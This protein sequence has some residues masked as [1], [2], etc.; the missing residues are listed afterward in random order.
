MQ[1]KILK[2]LKKIFDKYCDEKY[3]LSY[4]KLIFITKLLLDKV[5]L[6][7]FHKHKTNIY[8]RLCFDL[9]SIIALNVKNKILRAKF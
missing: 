1:N 8:F 3:F 6:Q 4:L 2:F 5:N 9:I 7:K